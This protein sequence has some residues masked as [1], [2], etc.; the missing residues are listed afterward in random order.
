MRIKGYLIP[1]VLGVVMVGLI[2][3]IMNR[4]ASPKTEVKDRL[5]TTQITTESTKP[6]NLTPKAYNDPAGFSFSYPGQLTLNKK[7]S[8]DQNVYSQIEL[9]LGK[10]DGS[11]KLDVEGSEI[12]STSEWAKKEKID[13][14]GIKQLKLGDLKGI[15][16]EQDNKIITVAFDQGV[17]FLFT[18]DYKQDK[19]YWAKILD[20]ITTSFKLAPPP[21][22][23]SSV[24]T[25]S[26]DE[27][28]VDEGEE[29][30]E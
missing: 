4:G 16:Y 12:I 26:G 10:N 6:V 7:E 20:T 8:K 5:A 19:E 21:P 24:G 18:V 28:F 23:E 17:S 11:V 27:G 30:I 29:V 14:K 1:A 9:I 15:Q 13:E 22:V 25:S 2:F 3:F